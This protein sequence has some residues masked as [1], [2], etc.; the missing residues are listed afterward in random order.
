MA[1]LFALL[2]RSP[3]A[4]HWYLEQFIFP[5]YMRHQKV[6]L[7]ASGQEVGGDLLF[8]RRIGFS[9]TPSDL[10]PVELG[11]C[12][13]EKGSDG[14]MV[15]VLTDPACSSFE[16]LDGAWTVESLLTRIARATD[17]P[18]R[19]LI[20]TGALITGY[21]NFQ[22]AKALLAYG[23]DWCDGVVFLDE[24][25]RK[26]I[27][28]RATGRVVKLE[29]SGVPAVRASPSTTRCTRR[30]WT[31]STTTRRSPRSPRQGH[32]LPRPRAG[33]VPHARHREGPAHPRAA[34][35]R[36]RGP[37]RARARGRAAAAPADRPA[38]P[39]DE[40]TTKAVLV[41]C[42]AWLIV[43][44]MRV[45]RVQFNQLCVQ[46][47]TN[48]FRKVA[49]REI[50]AAEAAGGRGR[51][52][53]A[54]RDVR[55][56]LPAG[57]RRGRGRRRGRRGRGRAREPRWPRR[58]RPRRRRPSGSR[59]AASTPTTCS[60]CR[61]ARSS[62]RSRSC[63]AARSTASAGSRSARAA[64]RPA[65]T[66]T[67]APTPQSA[68]RSTTTTR[69]AAS[70]SS[71]TRRPRS[72]ARCATRRCA[73]RR[74]SLA[75]G[76]APLWVPDDGGA[77]RR[78]SRRRA[79]RGGRGARAR[80]RG[81]GRARGRRARARAHAR[82]LEVFMEDIGFEVRDS[83]PDP[84]P[85]VET[86]EERVGRAAAFV[87][88]D[89]ERALV[90]AWLDNMRAMPTAAEECE[91]AREMV[92][93]MEEEREKEQEQEQEREIEIEKYVDLAYRRDHEKPKP[94]PLERL[95]SREGAPHVYAAS[96][97]RLHKRRP[98]QFPPYVALTDNYF[99]RGWVGERRLKTVVVIAE[100]VPDSAALKPAFVAPEAAAAARRDARDGR[101]AARP[102]R[103][104]DISPEE[105]VEVARLAA[106]VHLAPAEARALA[107]E[108]AGATPPPPQVRP[109]RRAR[110]PPRRRP[111]RR[112]QV[113]RA[114]AVDTDAD[115]PSLSYGDLERLLSSGASSG[116]ST[117]VLRRDLARRGGDAAPR[118]HGAR[119]PG[120]GGA[121]L[122][123]ARVELALRV[124]DARDTVL[125]ATPGWTPAPE[126]ATAS[127]RASLAYFN[128]NAYFAEPR[129]NVLLRALA[130]N[131][132]EARRRFYQTTLG[133][134]RRLARRWQQTPLAKV[135]VLPDAHAMLKQR[136]MAMRVRAAIKA[137]GWLLFDAFN[138]KFDADKNGLLSPGEVFGMLRYL[139]IDLA[140][141]TPA[142]VLDWIDAVDQDSDGNVS[143]TEFVDALRDP[144]GGSD[145]DA[146]D[147]DDAAAAAA[148]RP[149]AA[150]SPPPTTTTTTAPRRP[151][152]RA[153]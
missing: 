125:D 74:R 70:C 104:K 44:S 28:V 81:R 91:L 62:P 86:L 18:M 48:V 151:R 31:S 16:L 107:R 142:D 7:S 129:L 96:E 15:Q 114:R 40:Q 25:D 92:Q 99:D 138:S 71:G 4:I 120:A 143:Y 49:F 10:L 43:N 130:P 55:A 79:R 101:A 45:E 75:R 119:A 135:F 73:A 57:P 103:G 77:P 145:D 6:K 42:V 139:R 147:D 94:W 32:G 90:A 132:R 24:Y 63:P 35:P 141:L 128:G 23:L 21:S 26:M 88:S 110:S 93:E 134:R 59:R 54:L 116:T 34:H 33:R 39:R 102:R 133:C 72:T 47:V 112:R 9:G 14:Y 140:G 105:L 52:L 84:V 109:P 67:A 111:C 22:V 124:N 149:G 65:A 126:Y 51:R 41:A 153:R 89:A 38:P 17:P 66:P 30:A 56:Y 95:R 29:T 37:H 69:R 98:L 127:S 2:T 136:S 76:G 64:P 36:G 3:A 152:S 131:P 115:A 12:G 117:A 53:R 87:R 5:E 97:F 150:R 68:P 122:D 113:P 20:D 85:L 83:V 108:F 60:S 61:R 19:A 146:D 1:K 80:G 8:P 11:A 137:K 148:T 82:A 27:L 123:G 58:P 100:W 106:H 144:E 121:L 13:Y 78:S 118:D 46:N 50:A